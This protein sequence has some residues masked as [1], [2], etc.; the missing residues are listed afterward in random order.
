MSRCRG[1]RLLLSAWDPGALCLGM[2]SFLRRLSTISIFVSVRLIF[3][4]SEQANISLSVPPR[5]PYRDTKALAEKAAKKAAEKA[6]A[7]G[8]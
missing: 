5:L 8:K 2:F 4:L 1:L 6:A 7:A 3:V